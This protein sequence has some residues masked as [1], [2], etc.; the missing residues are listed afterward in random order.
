MP[1]LTLWLVR[2][3]ETVTNTGVWSP[4]PNETHLT[5][6]GKEQAKNAAA[7]VIEQPDLFVVSPFIRAKETMQ[8]FINQWPGT[9]LSILPIQEFIYLSPSR[10]ATLNPADR[11]QQIQAYWLRNDPYYCDG[12]DAESFAVFLQRIL[13]F[14]QQIIQYHGYAVVVGHGQFF[15]AFQLG[16]THGFIASSGWM[17][18]FREQEVIKPIKNGEII[19]LYFE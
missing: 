18:L 17:R 14:Y 6:N 2:H 11:K 16:L 3:G 12:D 13:S 1:R 9:P 10:L 8:L 19:E 5:L 15:K 4:Q 7:Q